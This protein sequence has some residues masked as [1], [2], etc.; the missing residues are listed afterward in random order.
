[1]ESAREVFEVQVLKKFEH[2]IDPSKIIDPNQLKEVEFEEVVEQ[3][4]PQLKG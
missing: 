2:G 1:M 3:S 4:A